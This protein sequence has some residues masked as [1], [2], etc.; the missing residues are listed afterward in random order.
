MPDHSGA[1]RAPLSRWRPL[2]DQCETH[3]LA[4]VRVFD[5]DEG[6]TARRYPNSPPAR[7]GEPSKSTF[8][9]SSLDLLLEALDVLDLDLDELV[10][11]GDSY[12]DFHGEDSGLTGTGS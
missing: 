12:S 1:H 2:L 6:N 9:H 8:F 3:G 11:G 7:I 10:G 4:G 5:L